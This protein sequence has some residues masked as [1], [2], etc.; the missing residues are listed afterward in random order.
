MKL[1]LLPLF[2]LVG[3]MA[4]AQAPTIQQS[5]SMKSAGSPKISPDGRWVAYTVTET[6]WEEN[7]YE[8][9]IWLAN[10]ATGEKYQLTNSK[11]SNSS[12]VWSPD[13]KTLAFLSTRDDKSQIYVI[14][15]QGGEAIAL[16]KFE[17]GVSY[18]DF[19]PNGKSIVFATT[20]PDSKAFKER[21]EKYSDY[22]VVQQDYKMT[23]L[24]ILPVSDTTTKLP[25]PKALTKGTDF[26]V[27]SFSFSPDGT[28]IA[29]DATKNPDLINSHTA[30]IYVLT[31]ADTTT[32]KIVSMKGPDNNPVW[33]PDGKQIA[34]V[35]ANEDEFFFYA[36]RL[37]ASVPAEGGTPT[38]LSQSFDENAGLLDWSS[39]GIWFGGLQKT[40]AHLFLLNPM[41]KKFTK[42]TQPDNLIAN[43]F[44]FTKDFKQ[45]AFVMA[46]PNQMGEIAVSTIP[47]FA[48][49]ILMQMGDQLKP[50]KTASR[51]VVSWKSRDGATIEGV[52]IKPANY[53]P[54]KK[55]PLLVVIHGGPTGIDMP[56]ITADRYYPI[57]LFTTKGALVLRP[58]YR[59]SAGYG[60]AFRALNVRNLGVGDYD[61]VI[62]GVDFLIGKGMV[63]KDKV[64]A[65]GWSQGGYISAFITT[66][67]DRFKATSVGAGISNWATY[68][69]NTDITP[70]TRQ[71][72]KGTPWNDPEIYKKTSPISYIKTAK[73][74]TLIQHGELDRRVPIANAYELRLALE[75][76]NVPVK[77]VVYKGFGHGI[78]KPKQMRQVME[79]NLQWFGK[80]V[81]GEEP[82]N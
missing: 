47:A 56:S 7:A 68:Y 20:V 42:I 75:D 77:M 54:A 72:L 43:Q 58:N 24:Y 5:I 55:Y 51:E 45:I 38:V 30:D 81:F 71:Y 49:K 69:Q 50:Y 31:L 52:L 66:F 78:T 32:R 74:P 33:S 67:S 73:T 26:S 59:G 19:S 22:E 79:E 29:F 82:K 8:T 65:M 4:F 62:S 48:P 34:F 11:K 35:T 12:P 80:W 70:F 53:D 44:S 23:H 41:T 25:M 40:S 21:V 3:A 27:G 18:F 17:T 2:C 16:T 60:K 61:D 36:N 9:E 13:G 6:N 37:I 46:S 10:T 76:N 64:G 28:K 15:P 14:K 39:E 57:E 1:H 63:D